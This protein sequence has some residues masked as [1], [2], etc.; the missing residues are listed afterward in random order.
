MA[1][2]QKPIKSR[3]TALKKQLFAADPGVVEA[4]LE[5]LAGESV[6]FAD[7]LFAGVDLREREALRGH[8]VHI[9]EPN[10]HFAKEP[11][12]GVAMVLAIAHA[13][14]GS[15]MG[16]L[17][18]GL[19]GLQ[20]HGAHDLSR[21]LPHFPALRALA[22]DGQTRGLEALSR[23]SLEALRVI[24]ARS[25]DLDALAGTPLRTLH[26]S[27]IATLGGQAT[28]ARLP[29]ERLYTE[30][31]LDGRH[32][33]DSKL[34]ELIVYA[35]LEGLVQLPDTLR[36]LHCRLESEEQL[37]AL[38]G[39]P[40]EELHV[41]GPLT[42]LPAHPSLNRLTLFD[43]ALQDLSGL[44]ALPKLETLTLYSCEQ[45]CRIEG[46]Q[47][48]ASLRRIEIE[49]CQQL[50][51]LDTL[52]GSPWWSLI[53]VENCGEQTEVDDDAP[54]SLRLQWPEIDNRRSAVRELEYSSDER[55]HELRVACLHRD[56]DEEILLE[57]AKALAA[58]PEGR[59]LVLEV[60][61]TGNLAQ[62]RAAAWACYG[63]KLEGALEPLLANF[64]LLG[65][66]AP[67]LLSRL[68]GREAAVEHAQAGC[69][70]DDPE[71]RRWSAFCLGAIGDPSSESVL[72]GLLGDAHT[73]V[74]RAALGSLYRIG[75]REAL[76]AGLE[77]HLPALA[78][79]A[80]NWL[81][82]LDQ[83]PS[84]PGEPP[85]TRI[86]SVPDKV[87][88]STRKL[89]DF[90]KVDC[91]TVEFLDIGGGDQTLIDD[92]YELPELP[93]LTHLAILSRKMTTAKVVTCV[94]QL[95]WLWLS[96]NKK[97]KQLDG[98]EA[99]TQ[100]RSLV[101]RNTSVKDLSPLG[102]LDLAELSANN[103]K[104]AEL[105]ALLRN[106]KLEKLSLGKTKLK[107][108][109]GIEVLE[110]LNLLNIG[111]TRVQDLRPLL[112][113]SRLRVLGLHDL[114]GVD[115]APL[116]QLPGLVDLDFVGT[117]FDHPEWL[118]FQPRVNVLLPGGFHRDDPL[119]EQAITEA[120]EFDKGDATS[121]FGWTI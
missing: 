111:G 14:A 118:L 2:K 63:P 50:P 10:A 46:A 119:A 3:I 97:L 26:F 33:A 82:L 102:A 34:R 17:R 53:R 15:V 16:R 101:I 94:P 67:L 100:L 83:P 58:T 104:V 5:T 24:N 12:H 43:A 66:L 109:E 19:A 112:K 79:L 11:A 4:G 107:S 88:L 41:G 81:E 121:N 30:S 93:K 22:L 42:R 108:I 90:A 103:S 29:L 51:A 115:F 21:L 76:T 45:L 86:V 70:A 20:L 120:L 73:R 74:R 89:P 35:P 52:Q 23:S 59:P 38:A 28:L 44:D 75:A 68:P 27:C 6:E 106:T 72:A 113:L 31:P 1:K 78:S 98:V 32:L 71:M 64:E 87:T 95:R 96:W 57:V 13:P 77:D 69:S 117:R 105:G 56:D 49:R 37:P 18:A 7:A 92:G 8:A 84:D 55:V 54:L 80:C 65:P 9:L 61:R 85:A 39:L 110:R 62:R 36:V 25:F 48:P 114:R 116:V 47:P 99:L 91:A 40:L 60:L